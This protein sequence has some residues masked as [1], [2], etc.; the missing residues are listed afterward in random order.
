MR[1]HDIRYQPACTTS[2]SGAAPPGSK[3]GDSVGVFAPDGRQC[4]VV[5]PDGVA[6]GD[7]FNARLAVAAMPVATAVGYAVDEK[8]GA[9]LLANV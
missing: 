6:P 5:I 1:P 7:V 4:A 2:N 3:P 9:S 8:E